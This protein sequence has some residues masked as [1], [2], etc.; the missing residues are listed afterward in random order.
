MTG[1]SRS[2]TRSAD[3]LTA[4]LADARPGDEVAVTF[5]QRVPSRRAG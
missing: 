5:E 1:S 3:D 2:P 4:A